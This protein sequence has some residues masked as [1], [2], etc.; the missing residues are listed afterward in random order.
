[1]PLNSKIKVP[2]PESGVIVRANG[3][4]YVYKV[5]KCFRNNKGQPTNTRKTIGRLDTESGMLI[6]NNTYYEFYGDAASIEVLPFHDSVK[7]I[8]STFLIRHILSVIGVTGILENIL[9]LRRAMAAVTAAI[10]M[11]CRW[12]VFERVLDWCVSCTTNEEPLSSQSASTLFA[13][14][15][16]DEKMAFFKTWVARN[17]GQGY[18]AY[19]VTSFSTYA[20]RISDTEWGYNRDNDKLP[21]I[22]LGCYLLEQS[23]LPMFYVTYPGSI[24]DKSHMPYMMA[25]NEELG[26]K[27]TG[28]IMDKGFCS[29]SNITYLHSEQLRYIMGVD[30]R[31]KATREAIDKVRDGII[32]LR[33]RAQKGVYARAVHSR[34]YG[35][36]STMHVYYNPE[37]AERQRRDLFRTVDSLEETI[38]QLSSLTEK[39]AKRY[40]RYFMIDRKINGT[41]TFHRDYDKIDIAARN[42]GFFCLL[43]NTDLPSNEI[44]AVYR[45]RDTI[46]KS[47]DD[48]KNH[49]DM[50]RLRTHTDATTDGKIF[51]AFIA[52]IAVSELTDKLRGIM[53]EKSMSKDSVISELEK[54]KT[55]AVS[56]NIRMINPLTK[57][58]REIFEAFGLHETDLKAFVLNKS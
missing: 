27:S 25:Y 48:I 15:T 52:L 37:L 22:N 8:G 43:S 45:R 50:K 54:I 35:V 3:N 7:S 47:F 13:G 41:F 29:T 5:L 32:S 16:H 39:E 2:L 40:M 11:T 30:M 1:M 23:G 46:E 31:H 34:F 20:E 58:Q 53:R 24:V 19:D 51:I 36:T 38:T 28:F 49:L 44:L 55:I 6:P 33:Y 57:T 9:G 21:Q 12:N 26:I 4:R 18:L 17:T 42:S 10:Y 14:I 56:N